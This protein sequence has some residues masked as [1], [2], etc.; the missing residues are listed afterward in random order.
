MSSD[1]GENPT[2]T[3]APA[4]GIPPYASAQF[5]HVVT[6]VRDL[7]H[8]TKVGPYL[9]QGLIGEGG[10]GSVYR[11]EQREPIH[12]IVALKLVKLGMDTREVVARFESE[13]QALALMDHPNVAKV[14][15]AGATETGRPYFVM[16]FVKGEPI[17]RYADRHKLTVRQ[18]LELFTQACDAIQHAH[19]KA[20]IHRDLKPSNIL[21]T[22]VS[23][24]PHVKVIDFGV[25]KAVSQRL[26][27]R[28]LFTETGQLV[29]T[30]EYM[31][32]EQ[33][34]SSMLDVDTR[35]D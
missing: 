24:K 34:E 9:I 22:T 16:E 17:T 27:E 30:P 10:M 25:A 5:A 8:P 15:D 33:A 7:G 11:A 3:S 31:A 28:T 1:S 23:D 2:P 14:L 20:I 32:P 35:A 12:R 19:Q 6:A 29:G 18:R 4:P 13:R 21:V 26:T